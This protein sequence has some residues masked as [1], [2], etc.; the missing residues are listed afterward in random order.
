MP[1]HLRKAFARFRSP[2]HKL[3]IEIG[4][5]NIN[6]ADRICNYCLNKSNTMIIED[7]FHAFFICPKFV[8]LRENDLSSWYRQCDSRP[9]I[10]RLLQETNTGIIKKNSVYL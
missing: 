4:H 1:F 10:F 7:E 8:V 5:H 2:S 3:S 6:R 9:E